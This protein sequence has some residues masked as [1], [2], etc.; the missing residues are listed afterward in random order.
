MRKTGR[1]I[2]SEWRNSAFEDELPEAVC[3]DS[4]T[5]SATDTI[6]PV[7][8]KNALPQ[9]GEINALAAG[10]PLVV[11]A[12]C[13]NVGKSMLF[14]R[15]ARGRRAIVSTVPGTT[16]D[17]NAA[18]AE[19]E[20]RKFLLI[21]SGGLELG[22]RQGLTPRVV[23]EALR[24]VAI[25]DLVIFVVDGRQGLTPADVEAIDLVREVGRPIIVAANKLDVPELE[26]LAAEFHALGIQRV[27]PTSGAH[28]RGV[29]ELLDF[30]ITL[31]PADEAPEQVAPALRLALIGR[32]N[33]GKSS[34]LNRLVGAPRA[35]V[36]ATP[37]TTR[38][39][40]DVRLAVDGRDL[41]LVDTAGIRRRTRVEGQIE[42]QSVRRAIET[43]RRAEVV[44]L[45][46][47]ASEG[48]TDQDARLAE[49]I[50]GENRALVMVCNK[51]D[52]AARRGGRQSAWMRDV[53]ER[54]AFLQYAPFVFT[55]ALTGDG[56]RDILPTALSVGDNF[57]GTFQTSRLNQVL[58]MAT[59]AMDPPVVA[60]RRLNLL[61]VTQVASA[62]PRL[63]IFSNLE[64]DI[65]TH[66]V[67]FL[68]NRFRQALGLGGTPLRLA[69]RKRSATKGETQR[70]P[71]PS[72]R[73]AVVD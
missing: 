38:D 20:G 22:E 44:L 12:G 19:H 35:I 31:L 73:G 72:A 62:P 65:P 68:E 32:P 42:Q 71:A 10:L 69:F 54:F 67:R 7:S 14:N 61:Y 29:T 11:L 39:A 36:D 41:L 53:R 70:K 49:L 6:D 26:G 4:R 30:A 33:V 60:G 23:A 55:S 57:R 18:A 59:Q 58:A 46:V 3:C 24:A 2:P 1:T 66:Y 16:R 13:A 34:L 8:I 28:G 15:I 47:D 43:V 17:L 63:V 25:A 40:L 48:V 64:R 50:A 27:F 9:A 45:V 21:D 51:W 37:G 52:A 56:V 5:P